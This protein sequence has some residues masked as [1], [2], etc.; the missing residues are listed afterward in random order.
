M[1]HHISSIVSIEQDA[2]VSKILTHKAQITAFGFDAGQSIQ[3]HTSV[4]EARAYVLEGCIVFTIDD[5]IY[6]VMAGEYVELPANIP[7]ALYVKQQSKMLLVMKE[8][9]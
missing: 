2:I 8:E 1:K 4:K 5:Q 6:E 7:H 3:T 9:Q